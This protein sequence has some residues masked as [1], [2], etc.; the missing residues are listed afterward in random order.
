MKE[1]KIDIVIPWVDGNDPVLNAKRRQYGSES[2][3][4]RDD[5]GGDTRFSDL[6][7]IGYCIRSIN[8]FA[9]FI[10]HIYIVSDGQDPHLESKIPL[11]VIDHKV[12][13]EGYEEYLPVFNSRAIETVIWRIPGLS[14]HYLLLNDDFIFIKETCPED[15][16]LPDGKVICYSRLVSSLWG[17][18]LNAL[19]KIRDGYQRVT[20][21]HS[22]IKGSEIQ[23]KW[24]HFFFYLV[25]TPRPQLKS[26]LADFYTSHP[27][28]VITNIRYRFRSPEQYQ[29]EALSY[30]I[31]WDRKICKVINP[32]DR[33]MFIQHWSKGLEYVKKKF[34]KAE[35]TPTV[36]FACFNSLDQ[37]SSEIQQEVFRQLDSILES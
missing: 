25:H 7:E 37:A 31:M 21:K 19:S 36:K 17:H 3:F 34:A 14:E 5:V 32:S 13:F 26:V 29:V 4:K 15:F 33:L 30:M 10:N 2:D 11:S 35:A 20:F 22:L 8:K 1:M 28:T 12:I 27:E 6:G 16:F 23:G 9:P 18:F 24:H